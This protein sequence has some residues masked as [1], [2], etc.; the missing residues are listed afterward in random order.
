M[1]T[2]PGQHAKMWRRTSRVLDAWQRDIIPGYAS[3]EATLD[4]LTS[5]SESELTQ[6][7]QRIK[8][9]QRGKP[10]TGKEDD[11]ATSSLSPSKRA[12]DPQKLD[13]SSYRD[14]MIKD[15]R[16][17]P[18]SDP[19]ASLRAAVAKAEARD[20][21]EKKLRARLRLLASRDHS[22]VPHKAVQ[23]SRATFPHSDGGYIGK[24]D[25]QESPLKSSAMLD[26]YLTRYYQSPFV[27]A[28]DQYRQTREDRTD[29]NC[30]GRKT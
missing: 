29:K 3:G 24:S 21:E 22:P 11:I 23:A 8:K 15:E 27:G 12:V 26:P 2:Q 9:R 4:D 18:S 17:D 7:A 25:R 10:K 14:R 13:P 19:L 5:E 6:R 28:A 30:A 16:R 1:E 20:I